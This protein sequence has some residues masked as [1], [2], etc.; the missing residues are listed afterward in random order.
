MQ[1]M[2]E[3]GAILKKRHFITTS[4]FKE[5]LVMLEKEVEKRSLPELLSLF[6]S[7]LENHRQWPSGPRRKCALT[8]VAQNIPNQF[9]KN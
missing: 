8:S 6:L 3:Q 9:I 5:Q 1:I 2:G 7:E 4:A